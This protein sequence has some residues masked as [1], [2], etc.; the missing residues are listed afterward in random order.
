VERVLVC[1]LV[2]PATKRGITKLDPDRVDPA[3]R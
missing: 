3:W 2:K 1:V